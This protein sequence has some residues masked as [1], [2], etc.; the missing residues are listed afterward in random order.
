MT[1]KKERIRWGEIDPR[2]PIDDDIIE[3]ALQ[4]APAAV[5]RR[6]REAA[7]ERKRKA[8]PKPKKK[9]AAKR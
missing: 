4:V 9:K 7:A 2:Q 8:R 1:E 3:A 6:E 5:E